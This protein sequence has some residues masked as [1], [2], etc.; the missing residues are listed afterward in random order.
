RAFG[1]AA[2]KEN[3][4]PEVKTRVNGE[5]VTRSAA[6]GMRRALDRLLAAW[7]EKTPEDAEAGRRQFAEAL[8]R[9]MTAALLEVG[10]S[11]DSE[12]TVRDAIL[13]TGV[14]DELVRWE[15]R[16]AF[17]EQLLQKLHEER[18]KQS[19]AAGTWQRIKEEAQKHSGA[20]TAALLLAVTALISPMSAGL[21][22]PLA[23]G[24]VGLAAPEPASQPAT[25]LKTFAQH[26]ESLGLS[27]EQLKFLE[28]N[29]QD[30]AAETAVP[31]VGRL[32]EL[33]K[34]VAALAR[35]LGMSRSALLVGPAGA[36][37]R[38][39]VRAAARAIA[40]GRYQGLDNV[41]L[42]ELDLSA[43]AAGQAAENAQL[44]RDILLKS[45]RRLVL[46]VDEPDRLYDPASKEHPLL[47]LLKPALK[48]G[49]VSLVL[50]ATPAQHKRLES[51]GLA[52]DKI[53]V[54]PASEAE[55]EAVLEAHAPA[56]E[57]RF[58][59]KAEPGLFKAAARLAARY[60]APG[61]LPGSA[62]DLLERTY[63]AL[64]PQ[65]AANRLETEKSQALRDLGRHLALLRAAEARGDESLSARAHNA[66]VADVEALL[67]LRRRLA[68]EPA[69]SVSGD[70]AAGTAAEL[71]GLPV[72]K[73]TEEESA[74]LMRLEQR[75]Q[76]RV[77][78]QPEAVT[79]VS[80]SVRRAR[81]GFKDPRKPMGA[82]IFLGPTGVGKTELAKALAEALFDDEKN[83]TR[84]DM[85]EYMEAHSVARLS[86]THPGYVG[87]DDGGQMTSAVKKRPYSVVLFDEIEKAH[88]QVLNAL[89]APLD[90]GVM[91]DGH[92]ETVSF[93]NTIFIM[94]GNLGAD[95]IQARMREG[96]GQ[97]EIRAEVME[98]V[99]LHFRPEFLNRIDGVIVFSGLDKAGA[100][101][102]LDIHMNRKV[103]RWLAEQ[104]IR[105]DW[106]AADD[107]RDFLLDK[108]FDPLNG[109]RPLARAVQD[110]LL[111]PL[112]DLIHSRPRDEFSGP[113]VLRT[114]LADGRLVPTLEELPAEE[115][116][117]RQ[118]AA[119]EAGGILAAIEANQAADT[120][121]LE[122][123]FF[124][125]PHQA[126][127]REP[128]GIFHPMAQPAGGALA[129]E[130]LAADDDPD[131]K[132]P[133]QEEAAATW[134]ANPDFPQPAKAAFLK[135]FH[136]A[137]RCA[138]STNRKRADGHPTVAMR[139]HK[140]EGYNEFQIVGQ[141]LTRE[142]LLE[143]A[144]IFQNHYAADSTG[145]DE[146]WDLADGLIA[147][148]EYGRAELF[149][150]KRALNSVP[151]ATFG[152]WSD[153]GSIAYWLRL[154]DAAAPAPEPAVSEPAP[155]AVPAE[156][157]PVTAPDE[158]VPP[159]A[160]TAPDNEDNSNVRFS[161]SGK[162]FMELAQSRTPAVAPQLQRITAAFL[163][164]G[165]PRT[166]YWGFK[167][168]QA[169][170]APEEF[171][172][173][174]EFLPDPLSLPE[175]ERVLFAEDQ[176]LRPYLSKRQPTPT[177]IAVAV[178]AIPQ[179]NEEKTRWLASA[180]ESLP[181]A[182]ARKI[183]KGLVGRIPFRIRFL[184]SIRAAS[185]AALAAGLKLSWLAVL[186]PAWSWLWFW[187]AAV[188]VAAA[189]V[190][191]FETMKFAMDDSANSYGNFRTAYRDGSRSL[192]LL[193]ILAPILPPSERKK[194]SS[195]LLNYVLRGI[196]RLCHDSD[197][198]IGLLNNVD[199]ERLPIDEARALRV[200]AKFLARAERRKKAAN[201]N[202]KLRDAMAPMYLF[203]RLDDAQ[204]QRALTMALDTLTT[205]SPGYSLR[206][207][208]AR[209]IAALARQDALPKDSER[210]VIQA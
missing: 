113:R 29:V 55:A 159:P 15:G 202:I 150:I 107:V 165:Q 101:E 172:K 98:A 46:V 17:V 76:S 57:A 160:A 136:K 49:R 208:S 112:A 157:A 33:Q 67:A 190:I 8:L 44:L 193:S 84:F 197:H 204:K 154:A 23:V 118:P 127:P 61:V 186:S 149:E 194:V 28:N 178:E 19:P 152:Y 54:P 180:L 94:T 10:L 82:F 38:G 68:A 184:G 191:I 156:P 75:L 173:L 108:G 145:E 26:L 168:A 77:V 176:A 100:A 131:L 97:D 139:W 125:D 182:Q 93:A 200:A 110:W 60:L 115:A 124:G 105:L 81:A 135:W 45:A 92:G 73:I 56:L 169:M 30:P 78:R 175:Q 88:P 187:P 16:Y 134:T 37:K 183:V 147:K 87:Y 5:L 170:L 70:D 91:T 161:E 206:L 13:R 79:A 106:P 119:P 185:W 85:S 25:G 199:L 189:A 122:A 52:F 126:L 53:E 144:R 62:V 123:L 146:S 117:R 195:L 71:S 198:L 167:A 24:A 31:L 205:A 83:L 4:N 130:Q 209:R 59:L 6:C 138:K 171:R 80:K 43:L 188:V 151:G 90:D 158:P 201:D 174:A 74:K 27:P 181:Q 116:Q 11:K 192:Q 21:L 114:E 86:G 153:S 32:P 66:V 120:P 102:V 142:E 65:A 34:L 36:G 148:G 128:L 111:D 41:R 51:Q 196:D 207:E 42:A 9:E 35:P 14:I 96:R 140:G 64:T 1:A 20:I 48:D 2:E 164:S 177:E 133:K 99:R 58:G 12:Q 72:A 109:G 103:G 141:P 69:A 155:V 22:G 121:A 129:G 104:D 95:I 137:V 162:L 203:N 3:D 40:E 47:Q 63:A 166:E 39:V 50:C 89:L 210:A 7:R 132:D 163:S 179:I 143:T 18:E